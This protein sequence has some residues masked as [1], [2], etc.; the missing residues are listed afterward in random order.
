M[1]RI[2][3]FSGTGGTARA[4]KALA[5]GFAARGAETEVRELRR[6]ADVP[7][8]SE[9]M[10]ALLFP[11]HAANAPTP[12]HEW[13]DALAAVQN[14]PAVVISVSGGGEVFPNLGC[15]AKVI[16]KLE[17]KGYRVIYEQTIVMPSNFMEAMPEGWA[18]ELLRAL[19]C[20]ASSIAEEVLAGMERRVKA[21]L[22]DRLISAL[23]TIG[24]VG[25]PRFGRGLRA[26]EACTG[27]GWCA[28][29]CPGANIRMKDG[30]PEFLKQCAL[31]T[32]CVYGCPANAIRATLLKSSVLKDG[33]DL[34]RYEASPAPHEEK[35]GALWEGVRRYLKDDEM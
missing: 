11:V 16:K 29:Q 26:T 24:Q 22:I 6:G 9:E 35:K 30:R 13:L 34:T 23:L 17:R 5:S 20:K 28:R 18:A 31:C 14:I 1:I 3:Y 21:R 33:F 25:A 2:A 12:V 8:G 7:N 10:L 19:P 15:R 4:A 32:R 27:C